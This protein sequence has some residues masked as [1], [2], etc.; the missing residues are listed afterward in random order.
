MTVLSTGIGRAEL[1][2]RP[3][4]IVPV[5]AENWIDRETRIVGESPAIRKAIALAKR[6]AVTDLPI[7]LAG[8]TGTGKELFAAEIHRWSGLP[9]SFVDV[10]CAALPREM[11]E[12]LLFG[13]R[14]GAFTGATDHASGLLDEAQGGTLFLDEML[15]M[16]TEIQS[17]LLRVLE[18]GE[19][20]RIGETLKRRVR[21]RTL[22][23]VQESAG[24]GLVARDLR[25]DLLQRVAGIVIELPPLAH[26]DDDV[27]LLA[28]H[29][30]ARKQRSLA[31][32]VAAVLRGHGWPGNVRELRMTIDRACALSNNGIL[33]ATAL[34]ESIGLGAALLSNERRSGPAA[35]SASVQPARARLL[36]TFAAHEW[37][38]GRT[39][40]ALGLGRTTLF[41]QLKF[42]G[43][44]LRQER[45]SLET[46]TMMTPVWPVE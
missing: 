15:S 11:V 31:S 25:A 38:A 9:G 43:I 4:R 28:S 29:F 14:R 3:H 20:R 21:F 17:K 30:A 37:N 7:L 36:A 35:E 27:I 41:K 16:P 33:G 46:R 42:L 24:E 32:D 45:S 12:A 8:P 2:S 6:V 26:R 44:S 13:H 23:A 18:T 10:N 40:Q 1:P 39:A 34:A 5:E 22:G 19:V